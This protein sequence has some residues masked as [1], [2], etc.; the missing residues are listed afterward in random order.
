MG[1]YVEEGKRWRAFLDLTYE[2]SILEGCNKQVMGKQDYEVL[3]KVRSWPLFNSAMCVLLDL[4]KCTGPRGGEDL[5]G[6]SA[7]AHQT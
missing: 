3:L 4:K 1:Q 5:A 7:V 2:H 6:N